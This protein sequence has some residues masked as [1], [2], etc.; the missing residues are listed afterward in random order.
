MTALT[1]SLDALNGILGAACAI[2]LR[3]AKRSG[4][5]IDQDL[6]FAWFSRGVLKIG[7]SWAPAGRM[8]SLP[9]D[10]RRRG[11]I[12]TTEERPELRAVVPHGGIGLEAALQ[13][14]LAPERIAS[15]YF[16]G[17]LSARIA[18]ALVGRC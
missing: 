12:P 9:S 15:E 5:P 11:I 16:Q 8:S 6:Y 2:K 18:E 14:A 4:G 3:P 17:P 13:A 7:V 1:L 10:A